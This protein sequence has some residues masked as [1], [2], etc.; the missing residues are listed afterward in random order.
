MGPLAGVT[1]HPACGEMVTGSEGTICCVTLAQQ[2]PVLLKTAVC[3]AA[4]SHEGS[5]NT[6]TGICRMEDNGAYTHDTGKLL[7]SLRPVIFP[8]LLQRRSGEV[9]YLL[10]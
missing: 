3:M 5:K 9:G 6:K 10:C 2:K 1:A 8:H 4:V 7:I